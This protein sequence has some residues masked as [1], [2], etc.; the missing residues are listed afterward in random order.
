MDDNLPIIEIP[1]IPGSHNSGTCDPR[2][3]VTQ[4]VFAL[5]RQQHLAVRDQLDAG[6]RLVDIRIRYDDGK[7]G[8]NFLRGSSGGRSVFQVVHT[9]DTRY[10]LEELLREVKEF[11]QTN[12]SEF[13]VVMLRGDWPPDQSVAPDGGGLKR[14]RVTELGNLLTNSGIVWADGVDLSTRVGD[15]RGM[16]LLLSDW[17]HEGVGEGLINVPFL[18]KGQ[19]YQVCDIWDDNHSE[20]PAVKVSRFMQSTREVNVGMEMRQKEVPENPNSIHPRVCEALPGSKL[21]TGVALDRTHAYVIPPCLTS[22]SWNEWFATEL[23]SNTLWRPNMDPPVPVG[24]VLIDFADRAILKRLL[25]VGFRMMGKGGLKIKNEEIFPAGTDD[26]GETGA[27][28]PINI[29][30]ESCVTNFNV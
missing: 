1:I 9:L 24:V 19:V 15:I 16:G 3:S 7:A 4:C 29:F 5:A 25:D 10:T 28:A 2:L 21:F 8:L 23:E 12:P 30:I 13:V 22:P 18:D 11:L 14:D 20:L 6:T 26:S 27:P 17:F